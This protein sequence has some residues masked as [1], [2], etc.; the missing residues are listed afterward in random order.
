VLELA[1]NAFYLPGSAILRPEARPILDR[2]AETLDAPL[3]SKFLI[4]IEGHT[5]DSPISNEKFASNWELSAARATNIVRLF[6]ARNIPVRRM[7][8]VAFADTQPKVPNRD[9]TGAALPE[10]QAKNRRVIVRIHR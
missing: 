4:A 2:V 3:Y 5:D 1:S 9:S 6:E 10:N 8:A 7:R